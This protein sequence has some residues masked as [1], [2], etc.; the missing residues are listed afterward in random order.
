MKIKP[1]LDKTC[2]PLE[3]Y[4]KKWKITNIDKDVEKLKSS[5]LVG[6]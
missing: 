4:N 1:Q 2:Y 3:C 6:R 5:L